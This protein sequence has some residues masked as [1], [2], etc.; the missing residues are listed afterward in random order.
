M[1][2]PVIVVWKWMDDGVLANHITHNRQQVA[3]V[4]SAAL[5]SDVLTVV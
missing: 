5:Y 2:K 1:I 3:N 4:S